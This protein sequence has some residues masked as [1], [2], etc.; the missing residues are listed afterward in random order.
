MT[1][2]GDSTIQPTTELAQTELVVKEL[3]KEVIK[4]RKRK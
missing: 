2:T 1:G 4:E 3:V